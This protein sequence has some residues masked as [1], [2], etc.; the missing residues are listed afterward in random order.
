MKRI[1]LVCRFLS[2]SFLPLCAAAQ[3]VYHD[4]A[5]FPLYGKAVEQT[6][7]RYTRL[8]ESLKGVTRDPVWNLGPNSAGLAIRFRSN[9]TTIAV[10]WK[11]SFGN[12]MNHMTPTGIRGLDLYAR[13]GKGW[14]FVNSARPNGSDN[15]ATIIST[16]LPEEREFILYLPLYDGVDSLDRRR[17]HGGDLGTATCGA[18]A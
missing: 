18:R 7:R 14:R 4:A 9:S 16:M 3:L 10:R 5:E 11:N 8:P 2:D 13:V 12:S 17:C 1:S 15:E 6:Y